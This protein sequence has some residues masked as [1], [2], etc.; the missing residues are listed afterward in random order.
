MGQSFRLHLL[1]F[2]Q[3]KFKDIQK[4]IIADL[5]SVYYD[6]FINFYKVRRGKQPCRLPLCK[7]HGM[8]VCTD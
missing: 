4:S 6:S 5:I 1:H 7:Q 8:E 3:Y 2:S